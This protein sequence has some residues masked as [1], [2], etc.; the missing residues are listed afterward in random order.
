MSLISKDEPP[1][2]FPELALRLRTTWGI[3]F[4]GCHDDAQY[5]ASRGIIGLDEDDDLSLNRKC[6]IEQMKTLGLAYEPSDGL[7][8]CGLDLGGMP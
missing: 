5:L 1:L 2:T 8:L 6:F 7:V 4:G 3:S